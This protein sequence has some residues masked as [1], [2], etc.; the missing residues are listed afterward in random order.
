MYMER[1]EAS[2]LCKRGRRRRVQSAMREQPKNRLRA[3]KKRLPVEKARASNQPESVVE[4]A[5]GAVEPDKN[6]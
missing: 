4:V 3:S 5:L 6:Q 2:F 1:A